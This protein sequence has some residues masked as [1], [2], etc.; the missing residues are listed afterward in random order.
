MILYFP[1]GEIWKNANP[2]SRFNI[3]YFHRY[4]GID[5]EYDYD[6]MLYKYKFRW[7]Y[8]L[9]LGW[10]CYHFILFLYIKIPK[11]KPLN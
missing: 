7:R 3:R 6:Y 10:R 1:L 4:I 11:R 5:K 9:W 2:M 8:S